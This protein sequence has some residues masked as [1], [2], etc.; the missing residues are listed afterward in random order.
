VVTG[1]LLQVAA[2][3]AVVAAAPGE[4]AFVSNERSGT[5]SV[6]DVATDRVVDTV[7]VNG[8]PR[9]IQ[10]APDGSR[11]YVAVSHPW[12]GTAVREGIVAIDVAERKVLGFIAAGSDPEQF[13]VSARPPRAYVSNEDVGTASI[14]DLR[15]GTVV[16]TPLVGIEPEGV[17]ISP[18]E[19]WVYVTAETSNTV[20]V[21]DT[22]KG[23]VTGSFFVDA[24]PRAAAF[25]PN[26]RFAFITAEIGRSVAVVDVRRHAVIGRYHFTQPKQQ[27]VGVTVSPDGTRIFVALSHAGQVAVVD[28][29][30]PWRPQLAHVVAVGQRPWGV[31]LAAGGRKL[32]VANGP[33]NDVSVVDT[34]TMAVTATVPVGDAP[35][36][37]AVVPPAVPSEG[38][39]PAP[40]VGEPGGE[41][42]QTEHQQDEPRRNPHE[43]PAELLVGQGVRAGV[44]R[45]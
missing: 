12:Y 3:A 27:P 30:D 43:E 26:G 44:D 32:Y 37:V 10:G 31:A 25:S 33:S 9:G 38:A 42:R 45:P 16:A 24:R 22:A 6:L 5:I 34:A 17:A 39:H 23:D 29:R 19:F 41:Q 40:G 8:R 7:T 2:L 18:D 36:G 14:T 13:A 11:V 20:S 21:I 1:S 28:V 4:L 35:W 15:T